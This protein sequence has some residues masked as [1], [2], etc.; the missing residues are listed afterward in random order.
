MAASTE[1][2]ACDERRPTDSS[3]RTSAPAVASE[4]RRVSYS[5]VGS[6]HLLSQ[7]ATVD[8]RKTRNEFVVQQAVI[9]EN[10]RR[11]DL[12]LLASHGAAGSAGFGDQQFAARQI[13]GA[14]TD[15]PERIKP[16]AGCVGEIDRR[17][18]AA[19][20]TMCLDR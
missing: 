18:A 6:G 11:V 7:F 12:M 10:V 19:T 8:L 13:P 16:S 3:A 2:S 17:R 20:H 14:Q 15:F 5:S 9:G 4:C 1:S